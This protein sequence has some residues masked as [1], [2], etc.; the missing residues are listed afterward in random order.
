MIGEK[1]NKTLGPTKFKCV[2]RLS[3][4]TSK[5][6]KKFQLNVLSIFTEWALGSLWSS[7]CDVRMHVCLSFFNFLQASHWPSERM[8]RSGPLIGPTPFPPGLPPPGSPLFFIKNI[9]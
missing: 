8:F 3:M 6:A 7:S 9:L 2:L 1:V 4:D 5:H